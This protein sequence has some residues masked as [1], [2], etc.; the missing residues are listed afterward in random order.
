MPN[1]NPQITSLYVTR[2]LTLARQEGTQA[3]TRLSTGL[4]INTAQDDPAGIAK[5]ARLSSRISSLQRAAA[6]ASD[7]IAML[8]TANGASQQ[9][10]GMLQRMRELALQSVSDT[11]S[12]QQRSDLDTEFQLLKA[13]ILQTTQATVWNDH[14]LLSPELDLKTP[15]AAAQ[16]TSASGINTQGP[17]SGQ[18]ALF[19]NGVEVNVSLEKSESE[20]QRLQKIV[21][22]VQATQDQ[23]GT[24][25]SISSQGGLR[26]ESIDGRDLSVWYDNSVGGLHAA[27]WGLGTL[28]AAQISTVA[29]SPPP[30]PTGLPNFSATDTY[31]EFSGVG[32]S[33]ESIAPQRSASAATGAG[34]LSIVGDTVFRGNGTQANAVGNIDPIKNGSGGQPLR[35]H[36][37]TEYVNG[38]FETGNAG[39]QL[40]EGWDI[41]NKSVR[42]GG[43]DLV[44]GFPTP[45]D[46][47]PAGTEPSF[48]NANAVFT[49]GLTNSGLL[50]GSTLALRMTS[51]NVSTPSYGV[52]HGPYIV[53]Q[54]S[55][56]LAAGNQVSFDWKAQGGDDDFD[57]YAY[58]LNT[59]T[60]QTTTLLNQTG[61][62]TPWGNVSASVPTSGNYK[63][64]FM[65]GTYDATGGTIAGA[66][67]FIDNVRVQ[68]MGEPFVPSPQDIQSL[69]ALV[70]YTNSKPISASLTLNGVVI[71]A[72]SSADLTEVTNS[73]Q[74]KIQQQIDAGQIQNLRV[75]RQ[76][77]VLKLIATQVGDPFELGTLNTTNNPATL[78][79]QMLQTASSEE[80]LVDGFAQATVDTQGARVIPGSQVTEEMLRSAHTKVLQIGDYATDFIQFELPNLGPSGEVL[81]SL[82]WDVALD[83]PESMNTALMP[84]DNNGQTEPRIHIGNSSDS[85][86]ALSAID[87]ALR[88]IMEAQTSAGAMI[89]RLEHVLNHLGNSSLHTQISKSELTDTDYARESSQL[90]RAQLM[91]QMAMAALKQA[92]LDPRSILNL[93]A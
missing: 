72:D 59:D 58:L 40:V 80:L 86:S 54:E 89:G 43:A 70:S 14:H 65:S 24:Q 61:K 84:V 12:P 17:D 85:Q 34:V 69:Q 7:G 6:N 71:D 15:L 55:V 38:N 20:S 60:G 68:G 93:L 73:L 39:D 41:Q 35:I 76:D 10:T 88:E 2:A 75:E 92:R 33:S 28:G 67:L 1:F 90:S 66:Q 56:A 48:V 8:Q 30:S 27:H 49:S 3:S 37:K 22:A 9:I 29:L 36:L 62:T 52:V 78:A 46:N 74:T 13:Q 26:L 32:E 77:N 44:G 25:A 91:E 16:I 31:I 45:T 81:K 18:Y 47:A 82:L 19:I 50:S 23:H 63:F 11:N 21:S 83:D 53:S 42:L 87:E 5:A 51:S 4:Q 79:L 64:V 57:V